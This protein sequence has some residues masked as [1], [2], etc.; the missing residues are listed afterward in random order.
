MSWWHTSICISSL[1]P[2]HVCL[3]LT[4][5]CDHL[6]WQ[7]YRAFLHAEQSSS[8]WDCHAG[9][10]CCVR[11][12]APT[13][14][15]MTAGVCVFTRSTFHV[16]QIQPESVVQAPLSIKAVTFAYKH[17]CQC[18]SRQQQLLTSTP[19]NVHQSND[20]CMALACACGFVMAALALLVWYG[21]C[22]R[23]M[24]TDTRDET[25]CYGDMC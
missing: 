23:C 6:L 3:A 25:C 17:P 15:S 24:Q 1:P 10:A 2:A 9:A 5:C 12:G 22:D 13:E 21:A 16:C 20:I 7:Y 14:H 8:L 19:I 18:A 4:T 11:A